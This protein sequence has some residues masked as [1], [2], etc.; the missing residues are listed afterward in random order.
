MD[1]FETDRTNQVKQS[2]LKDIDDINPNI[3]NNQ[4]NSIFKK[5]NSMG[6]IK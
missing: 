2:N 3:N 4:P 5:L 1:V 6:L